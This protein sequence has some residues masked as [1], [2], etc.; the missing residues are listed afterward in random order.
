MEQDKRA[1][2]EAIIAD[3]SA[4]TMDDAV[5]LA[6]ELWETNARYLEQ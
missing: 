2:T 1:F 6:E 5:R 3:G 4:A